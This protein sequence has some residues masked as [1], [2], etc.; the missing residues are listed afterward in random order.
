M[1]TQN[2]QLLIIDPQNDFCHPTTGTLYVPGADKD[3]QRLAAFVQDRGQDI[4]QIHVTLDSHHV[5]DIAHPIWWQDKNGN[6]P[7]PFTIITETDV[8]AGI[9]RAAR[10]EDQTRSTDYVRQLAQN[11]RYPLCIW[12][13]HCLIGSEGHAVFAELF[14]ALVA[15]E[16]AHQ[17]SVNYIAKGANPYTEHYSAI[18]ADVIDPT[19]PHTERNTDLIAN[20][21]AADRVY[22]AGEAGSHCVANTVRDLVTGW[23]R[24]DCERLVLLTDTIS[25]VPGFDALQTD[26]LAEMAQKYVTCQT[27][28]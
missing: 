28:R 1:N 6:H 2:T 5:R 12:P 21:R 7:A 23:T 18:Q 8:N 19:D 24:E 13:Y 15:W 27:T 16:T 4:S 22:I 17:K 20:L 3:M 14:T 9:W 26:F 11:K 10:D 25:S